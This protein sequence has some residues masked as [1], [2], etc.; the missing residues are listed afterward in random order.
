MDFEAEANGLVSHSSGAQAF[1][2]LFLGEAEPPEEN[3]GDSQK[4]QDRRHQTGD[5]SHLIRL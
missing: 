5:R 2:V 4:C 3:Q 1:G